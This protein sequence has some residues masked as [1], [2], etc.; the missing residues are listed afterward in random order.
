MDST[1][2]KKYIQGWKK[3]IKNKNIKREKSAENAMKKAK[4]IA[5]ILKTH[6]NIEKVILFG[7]LAEN[8]FRMESDIDLALVNSDKSQYL[9]MYNKIYDIASPYKVDLL[10][11]EEASENLKKRISSKGVEL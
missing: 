4:K 10:P 5:Q 7:S 6:Y 9:E 11:L 2:R 3:R 1:K 8:N